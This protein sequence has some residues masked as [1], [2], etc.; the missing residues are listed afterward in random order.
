MLPTIGS[1]F[2]IL[3]LFCPYTVPSLRYCLCF[4]SQILLFAVARESSKFLSIFKEAA[5]PFKGKVIL[6]VCQNLYLVIRIVIQ[7]CHM[8]LGRQLAPKVSV[9]YIYRPRGSINL[10]THYQPQSDHLRCFCYVCIPPERLN[11]S[12]LMRLSSLTLLTH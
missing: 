11:Q 3:T 8:C 2:C 12:N 1:L 6:S 4:A 7:Y 10:I 9:L 5:K